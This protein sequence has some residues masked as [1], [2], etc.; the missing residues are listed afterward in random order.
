MLTRGSGRTLGIRL[1]RSRAARD[2]LRCA[3]QSLFGARPLHDVFALAEADACALGP[4]G[5]PQLLQTAIEALDLFHGL[6]ITTPDSRC[7]KSARCMLSAS[8]SEWM[9][10]IVLIPINNAQFLPSDSGPEAPLNR[11]ATDV[12]TGHP[13]TR[14][15]VTELGQPVLV[16]PEV[17]AELVQHRD[18]DLAA[19][20]LSASGKSS[21]SG[22][23]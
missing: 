23:R 19:Q 8:I 3:L 21:S 9:R 11:H 7:H 17:V 2:P 20:A 10:V 5:L 6:R 4:M 1:R 15:L 22:E 12:I 13:E 18:P 16:E 14:S